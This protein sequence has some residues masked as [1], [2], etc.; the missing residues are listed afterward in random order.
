[1]RLYHFT[2]AKFLKP[3][4]EEG[5][6]LGST[7][8]VIRCEGAEPKLAVT[9]GTQWLT[10]NKSFE[11]DW[12]PPPELRNT[13]YDRTEFR[14]TIDVPYAQRDRVYTWQAYFNCYMRPCGYDKLN[15]FDNPMFCTPTDWRIFLGTVH[16]LWI[17]D[18]HQKPE[19]KHHAQA[20]AG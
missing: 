17:K 18:Y 8:L 2:A 3:I 19:K 13:P 1:M 20:Q 11:Q 6:K 4:L 15:N 14:L 16:P 5:L 7:P 9:S 12:N 10:I